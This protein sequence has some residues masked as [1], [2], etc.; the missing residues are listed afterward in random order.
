MSTCTSISD[1]CFI[2]HK[3]FSSSVND[4]CIHVLPF[5][6]SS[7]PRLS[8]LVARLRF[9]LSGLRFGLPPSAFSLNLLSG[10]PPGSAIRALAR[11]AFGMTSTK[12]R[13]AKLRSHA[14]FIQ[15]LVSRLSSLVSR[16]SSLVSRLSY[17]VSG[18][19]SSTSQADGDTPS[20][21]L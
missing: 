14:P 2:R 4:N 9:Q 19:M 1:H 16:L 15:A 12:E 20:G 7:S 10:D 8:T 13:Q 5:T 18:L 17:Q 11:T 21:L 6:F 3:R